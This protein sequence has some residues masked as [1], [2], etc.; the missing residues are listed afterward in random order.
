[1]HSVHGRRL[2]VIPSKHAFSERFES[3]REVVVH[4]DGRGT[5][6]LGDGSGTSHSGSSCSCPVDV[7]GPRGLRGSTVVVL[8]RFEEVLRDMHGMVVVHVRILP[9]SF[10]EVLDV[11]CGTW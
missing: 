5:R 8:G 9:V 6:D 11:Q 1:M 10:V 3:S 4:G 7:R 2:G